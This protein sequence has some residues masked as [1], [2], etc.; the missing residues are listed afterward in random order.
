MCP[1]H[2]MAVMA[3]LA[4]FSA[5]KQEYDPYASIIEFNDDAETN[6]EV[7][8]DDLAKLRFSD[9]AGKEVTLGQ[10]RGQKNVVLV[11]TRGYVGSDDPENPGRGSFCAYCSTQASRLIAN[12]SKFEKRDA[13]ILLVFPVF[14]SE[15]AAQLTPFTAYV[16][17]QEKAKPEE[18]PFPMVLDLELN[19]V[20][21]LGI[22]DDLS[23]PA[24]YILDKDGKV[25][26]AYVGQ[27]LSDRP[28]VKAMLAQLDTIN[29][30]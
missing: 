17:H 18:V 4:L 19:A 2:M 14:R 24:T 1:A 8:A 30:K 10:F 13:E 15:D 27:S 29:T 3:T 7:S 28:S 16:Q 11:M 22:R 21:Q 23:K 5:C 9:P 20:N 6:A 12:Y 26:F 25:R